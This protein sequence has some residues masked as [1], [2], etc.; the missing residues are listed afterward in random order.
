MLFFLLRWV[1]TLT[2]DARVKFSSNWSHYL[3]QLII[4]LGVCSVFITPS[5]TMICMGSCEA[6]ELIVTL[7]PHGLFC[8]LVHSVQLDLGFFVVVFSYSNFSA[9]HSH[10]GEK[11]DDATVNCFLL[12]CLI[13]LAEYIV[14]S[15]TSAPTKFGQSFVTHPFATGTSSCF[16]SFTKLFFIHSSLR[17]RSTSTSNHPREKW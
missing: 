11:G 3:L 10:S 4:W 7:L 8:C 12:S 9:I 14:C 2:N 17:R 16:F 13:S 6:I 5:N 15:T 1:L